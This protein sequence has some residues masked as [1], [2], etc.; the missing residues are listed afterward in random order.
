[1]EEQ[2]TKSRQ[3]DLWGT[4]GKISWGVEGRFCRQKS[5]LSHLFFCH[6][7]ET[8]LPYLVIPPPDY[9]V[10]SSAKGTMCF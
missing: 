1:M 10:I 3:A 6:L 2:W 9:E 4:S 8:S 7:L 5:Y